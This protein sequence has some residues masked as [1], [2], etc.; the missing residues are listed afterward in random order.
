MATKIVEVFTDDF[1]GSPATQ[2]VRFGLGDDVYEVDLNGLHGTQLKK[3]LAPFIA[4]SRRVGKLATE[5]E[6][7]TGRGRGSGW[8]QD[9]VDRAKAESR[10]A[11]EWARGQGIKVSD[12]GSLRPD[13]LALYR[14]AMAAQSTVTRRP[15]RNLVAVP[16]ATFKDA[17]AS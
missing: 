13:I 9:E 10:A 1:D 15:G 8:L 14:D 5:R 6:R 12:R 16:V 3:V 7:T 11:R 4:V 2:T 17:A